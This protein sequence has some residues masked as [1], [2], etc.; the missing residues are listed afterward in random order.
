MIFTKNIR[1]RTIFL[2]SNIKPRNIQQPPNPIDYPKRRKEI[3]SFAISRNVKMPARR[4]S[5]DFRDLY[6]RPG[7]Q[8]RRSSRSHASHGGMKTTVQGRD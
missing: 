4:I 5:A 2:F 8:A 7:K 6:R 3:H 1:G